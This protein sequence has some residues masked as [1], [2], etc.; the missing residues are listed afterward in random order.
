MNTVGI[1]CIL[2]M[3]PDLCGEYLFDRGFFMCIILMQHCKII[4]VK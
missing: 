3:R 1:Y 4:K 2:A